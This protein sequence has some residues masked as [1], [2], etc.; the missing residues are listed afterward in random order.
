VALQETKQAN[1]VT[2]KQAITANDDVTG[3]AYKAAE[4]EAQGSQEHD[5]CVTRK[6]SLLYRRLLV[7][8]RPATCIVALQGL[9]LRCVCI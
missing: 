3:D 9:V 5:A 1:K 8:Q 7:Q 4:A 6:T 2:S